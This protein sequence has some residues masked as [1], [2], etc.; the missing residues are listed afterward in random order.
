[1][2]HF[3]AVTCLVCIFLLLSCSQTNKKVS[4]GLFLIKKDDKY[5]YMDSNAKI[6]IPPQFED[7]KPFSEGLAAVKL[8]DVI[9]YGYIDTTGKVVIS[10]RFYY[11]NEFSDGMAL[12]HDGKKYGYINKEGNTIVAPTYTFAQTFSDEMAVIRVNDKNGFIDTSGRVVIDPQ[13]DETS[14]FS[15]GLAAVRV[16]DKFGYIDKTGKMVI[17]PQFLRA[18][19]FSEGLAYTNNGYVDK[20]GKIVI[21]PEVNGI[22]YSFGKEF[23][24]GFAFVRI[25]DQQTWKTNYGLLKQTGRISMPNDSKGQIINI[26]DATSFSNSIAAVKINGKWGFI[27]EKEQIVIEPKYD[28]VSPFIA[29]LTTVKVGSN[30]LCIDKQG[31]EIKPVSVE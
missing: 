9:G 15:E 2:T 28:E 29:D 26:E 30:V 24:E 10:P 21:P 31:Q 7:A 8:T 6:V 25:N 5:G 23:S 11:A 3:K 14:G 19:K 4:D 12:I 16:G 13:Y 17:N 22:R 18:E 20:N 1:M 27:N